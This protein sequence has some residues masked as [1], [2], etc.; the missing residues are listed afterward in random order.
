MRSALTSAAF[1]SRYLALWSGGVEVIDTHL[2]GVLN[3]IFASACAIRHLRADPT[4]ACQLAPADILPD[5]EC[6]YQAGMRCAW[7][8]MHRRR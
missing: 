7:L 6:C 5:N 4:V 2:F 1:H 8:S 3:Q